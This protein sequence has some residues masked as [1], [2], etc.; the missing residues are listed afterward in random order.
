MNE[1]VEITG[2]DVTKDGVSLGSPSIYRHNPTLGHPKRHER[3]MLTR[4]V[5]SHFINSHNREH[6]Q[7]LADEKSNGGASHAYTVLID[8][9]STGFT[10]A[11]IHFQRGP[12][13]EVGFNG[14]TDEALLA[15][16]TDRIQGFQNGP[17]SCR[18]N[19]LALTKP[20]EAMHWLRHRSEDRERRQVEGTSKV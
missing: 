13:Q 20:Q 4:E 19:A 8:C 11:T 5:R 7:I 6:V 1:E 10:A 14:L 17:F 15:I 18:E 3:Y 16:V 2:A 12:A 9:G